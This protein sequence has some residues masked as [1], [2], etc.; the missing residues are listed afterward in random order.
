MALTYAVCAHEVVF[1]SNLPE[2][3][4]MIRYTRSLVLVCMI[5]LF[6]ASGLLAQT[7]TTGAVNGVITD[8]SGAVIPGAA[9]VITDLATGAVTKAKSSNSGAYRFD[10]LQPGKY[11]ID[12]DQPG[13]EKLK[14]TIQ[15][16]ASKVLDGNL[17]L[18]IGS[19]QQTISV[20]AS[21]ALIEAENGNI[22]N[23]VS[24]VEVAEV[25]NSGNNLLFETKITPGF[26][27]G[28]SAF[29]VVGSTM[30]Q[31]D[32]ENFNDPY[33]NANNSGASNL[34]LGLDD[35]DQ[36]VVTG[37]GYSG[38]FG[39]LVGA[40]VSFISKQGGNRVHGNANWF[41][42]GR[43]LVANTFAHK[44]FANTLIV[45]P[46][47]PTKTRMIPEG[48]VARSFENANQ[49]AAI[50]SGPV[51]VPHLFSGKDKLFF[52]ADAEG[53]RAI[54]PSAPGTV[55][56]PSANLQNYITKTTLPNDG[57]ALSIPFY[58]KA[59]NLYNAASTAHNAA[60]NTGNPNSTNTTTFP[61]AIATGCPTQA[62]YLSTKD[63]V[64][65]GF[66]NSGTAAAPVWTGPAGACTVNY[67]SNAVTV[68]NEALE[69]FRVDYN[70]S[71]R[72]K[73]FI[74][75]EHD[76]GFQPTGTDPINPGFNTIS[77]QPQHDGQ[78]NETHT[79][80]ARATN[81]LILGGLWYHA[82]FGPANL[83][84]NLAL[85][86]ASFGVGTLTTIN[87]GIG[88]F[89][90]GRNITTVQLQDDFAYNKGAHTIKVGA[91]AYYIK[92]NDNYFNAGIVPTISSATLG[93]YINGGTDPANTTTGFS[94]FQQSFPIK[95]E[96]P[97]G[98]DQWAVYLED[99][100]KASHALS[101]TAALRVEHQGNVKCLDNCLTEVPNFPA[102]VSGGGANGGNL[103]NTPYNQVYKFTQRGAL[104]GLQA[105]ELEPRVGFAYNPP[106]LHES[107]VVR[108]GYGI[109]YDGLASSIIE[110]I[111]KNP[112]AKDTFS[113][114]SD[115]V[116]PDQTSN[117]WVDTAAYNTAYL[118]G[119]TNGGTYASIKASVPTTAQANFTPPTL[120]TVQP[121]LKMY[122]VQ[123]W[124]L[125]IQKQFGKS[126]VLSINYL[127]NHGTHKIETDA[128]LNA[129]S[130]G[131]VAGLPAGTLGT[132]AVGTGGATVKTVTGLSNAPIDPR[133]GVV[134]YIYSG[135]SNN[136]NG[137][138]VSTKHTFGGGSIISA[139]YTFGKLMD[140]GAGGV[141]VSTG[142]TD[143]AAVPDPYNVNKFYGPAAT[144]QRHNFVVDYV[145][146]FP[147]GRGGKFFSNANGF[148]DGIIGGW[149]ASGSA[150]AYSG[151]PFSV[152][153]T[154]SATNI[155]TYKTG[156]NGASLLAVYKGGG[157]ATCGYAL[158]QCLTTSQFSS[159]TSV[160]SP[161]Y[162][163][164]FR[165]PA[166]AT[167]D[168]AVAKSIPLHWEGGRFEA[169][170]QAF[171]V[172]NHLNFS[173]PT[174]SL[175]STSFAKVTGVVNPSGIFSGVGGDDSPRIV[176]LKAKI[177]F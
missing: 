126:T 47:D 166:Y 15:I 9:V 149:Q 135:G 151:L 143:F 51:T 79:F 105:I 46:T 114:P 3:L 128:G 39:G 169:S 115:N 93:A 162:R 112:P 76:N 18:T 7:S 163:N 98:V 21:G 157:E 70:I 34:T 161:G 106:I 89:P 24:A 35:I 8:Q 62:N 41:W 1:A 175:S 48:P 92:E 122:N 55:L 111:A 97:V 125:E 101:I 42:T 137:V 167:T 127:G 57:L 145:Y 25:P 103:L 142:T 83:A 133:F 44:E 11:Q 100:W 116:S 10:L 96:H 50:I 40:T 60:G 141:A 78:I 54:L 84:S 150:F 146:K 80:G 121:N 67:A 20:E 107:M 117:L 95:T 71:S 23:T 159:A 148:V 160:N 66:V 13:F 144:D 132:T 171:N 109:F 155:S 110:T 86:P 36:A 69:I 113:V 53:L 119:I 120:Y 177:V 108:G 17:K 45:D 136:Y 28:G 147:F 156:A 134:Y 168:F 14:S 56:L 61:N 138:I 27:N 124:N 77:L 52:L 22:A 131:A 174:G 2:T 75:Y 30:Y 43:S 94:T 72:D 49:W 65:L 85:F 31:I 123:K 81:N 152:I 153:D 129:Y 12:I 172:L 5:C 158:Q 104:P 173:R 64:G 130:S 26:N 90:T 102:D 88:S 99:D 4:S 74:R 82:I 165:G 38:Q 170:A 68:A 91:K 37:N 32:G 59:F 176:Q 58:Q 16:D 19:D 6:G 164:A 73:A 154:Q 29:G 118:A 33:N 140:N 87:S 139:G 63:L